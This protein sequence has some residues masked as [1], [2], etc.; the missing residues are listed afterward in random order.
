[1]KRI[2]ALLLV[3]M[4]LLALVACGGNE[5]TSKAE[6]TPNDVSTETSTEESETEIVYEAKIPE[7]FEYFKEEYVVLTTGTNL[8]N[9]KTPEFGWHSDELESSVLNDA[10]ANR[11]LKVEQLTGVKIVEDMV[12]DPNRMQS[13]AMVSHIQTQI[14][15]GTADF[16]LV[17]PSIYATAAVAKQGFLYDLNSVDN[18]QLESEWWDTFLANEAAIDGKLFFIT[19]DIGSGSR[20]SLT[21]VYFNKETVRELDLGDPYELV[22]SKKWTLDV[23][24]EWSKKISQDLDGDGVVNYK[25]KF[26]MGGQNDNVWAFFYGSGETISSKNEAG[27]P[28]ITIKNDRS[29]AV[30]DKIAAIVTNKDYFINANDFFGADGEESPARLLSKAFS[31][32]RSL[33]FCENL[34]NVEDLR[35]MEFD[36]GILPT[37]LYDEA[38]ERYYSLL[39]CWVSNAFGIPTN[40]TPDEADLSA[41]IFNVLSAEGKNTV[42]PAYVETTLKGQRFRDDESKE[43]LDIIFDNIGC[44]IGHIYDFGSMGGQVLHQI[45]KGG[46]FVS[47]VDSYM[48]AANAAIDNLMDAFAAIE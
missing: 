9:V 8:D 48:N 4:M 34:N 15:G 26:G 18:M 43:M 1:M 27:R 24:L 3:G 32:G 25:D 23:V 21:A 2:L 7:G 5:D 11:N 19:G 41:V 35:N 33:F 39:N 36:F 46:N 31:E 44:D 38:Q 6:S 29:T 30:V 10:I 28:V 22:R 16:D 37:P 20:G 40:L 17:A 42:M 14:G 45:P 47:L 12:A 13:G